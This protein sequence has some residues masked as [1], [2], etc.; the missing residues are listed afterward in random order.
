LVRGSRNRFL[1]ENPPYINNVKDVSD[2]EFGVNDLEFEN[3]EEYYNNEN[4]DN[5]FY[6]E[7]FI[8]LD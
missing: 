5:N 1:L 6:I 8:N 4:F 2:F 7:T 3:H